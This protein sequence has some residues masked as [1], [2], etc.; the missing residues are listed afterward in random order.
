VLEKMKQ[1][2]AN[3]MTVNIFNRK[4]ATSE[5]LAKA[6]RFQISWEFYGNLKC[7]I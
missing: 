2:A 6:D 5:I 1:T 7:D 4:K 3:K